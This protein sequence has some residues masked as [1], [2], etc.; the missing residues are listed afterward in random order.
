MP[1]QTNGAR[2]SALADFA[3]RYERPT[4]NRGRSVADIIVDA[5]A[6]LH[7]DA[8][9]YA[10]AALLGAIAAAF[11]A[12]VLPA[13]GGIVGLG[14][15]APAVFIVAVVTYANTCAA[16]RRAQENLEPDAV[17]AF[18]AVLARMP[19]V[20]PPLALPLVLTGVSVLAGVIAAKWAPNSVM[21]LAVIIVFAV[22]GLSAFQ[23]SLYIP[24]LFARNVSFADARLLGGA[25]MR[26]AGVLV[27]ACFTIVMA[28]AALFA[29]LALATG[30]SFA[31]TA[32]AVFAFVASM[33]IAAT[34]ATLIY[35][36]IAP[37]VAPEVLR[38]QRQT[39]DAD[40]QTSAR[41]SR[42]YAERRR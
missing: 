14:L 35:D 17:R 24:A 3:P 6:I 37:Q 31:A 1:T 7:Q 8:A 15:M 33:P 20:L 19:A 9:E 42:Q 4:E 39:W 38:A 21:T 23:R 5:L 28:P 32:V 11:A 22:A 29:M 10:F 30:F 16:V 34:I 18:F 13:A 36:G 25:A 2:Q 40:A 26:K 41:L 27:G 12:L